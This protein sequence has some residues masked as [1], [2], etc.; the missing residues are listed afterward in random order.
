VSDHDLHPIGR[1]S[2]VVR[3]NVHPVWCCLSADG[4][5]KVGEAEM[6]NGHT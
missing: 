3:V 4:Y 5:T 1:I 2:P 6:G